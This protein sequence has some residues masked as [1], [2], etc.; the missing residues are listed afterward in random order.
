[1]SQSR[2]QF[3]GSAVLTALG[4]SLSLP[5]TAAFAQSKKKS[6]SISGAK[7]KLTFKPYDLQLRHVF[8]ISNF[9]RTTTP[10]VLTE[11]TYEGVTGYGEAS[12][13]PYLGETQAS[14]LDFLKKVNLEQ[15]SNPFDLDDILTYVDSIA[16]NNTAAKASVDIALHDLVGKLMGKPWHAIW[17]LNKEKT[18]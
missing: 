8:T 4:A 10:V 6:A 13:P 3:L 18:P 17:G 12:M 16:E 15:F 5:A 2:R 9:S 14:V 7:L 1:M 11:I